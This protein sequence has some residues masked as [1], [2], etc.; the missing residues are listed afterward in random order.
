MNVSNL[1]HIISNWVSLSFMKYISFSIFI[2]FLKNDLNKF[3]VGIIFKHLPLK[4]KYIPSIMRKFFN[5]I[6]GFP[7]VMVK[8]NAMFSRLKSM[9]ILRSVRKWENSVQNVCTCMHC[10]NK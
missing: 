9:S 4:I 10:Q 5:I 8:P 3:K 7:I 2:L 1:P 6:S